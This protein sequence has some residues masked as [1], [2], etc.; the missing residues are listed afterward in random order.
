MERLDA[1]ARG[2]NMKWLD[3]PFFNYI[4]MTLYFVNVLH[5]ATE[6]KWFGICYWLSALA[7]TATITFLKP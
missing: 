4:I 6:L 1:C 7:I 5:H 3:P 2:S